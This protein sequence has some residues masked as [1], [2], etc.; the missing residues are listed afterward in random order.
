MLSSVPPYRRKVTHPNGM[1]RNRANINLPDLYIYIFKS[2][3]VMRTLCFFTGDIA[4]YPRN[5]QIK[6]KGLNSITLQTLK[7]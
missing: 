4:A 7:K 6:K 2:K 3:E 5:K 1:C